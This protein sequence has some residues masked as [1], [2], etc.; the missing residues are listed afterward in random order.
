[1]VQGADTNNTAPNHNNA[2]MR[3]H[4]SNSLSKRIRLRYH[5]IANRHS[6]TGEIL[7]KEQKN[8]VSHPTFFDQNRQ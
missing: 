7:V 2:R 5:R 3:F 1:M 4:V 8:S 6:F